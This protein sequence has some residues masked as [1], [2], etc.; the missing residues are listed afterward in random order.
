MASSDHRLRNCLGLSLAALVVSSCGGGHAGASGLFDDQN[1][2]AIGC[3]NHQEQQPGELYTGGDHADTGHILEMMQYLTRHGDEPY[4]D[5]KTATA[6]DAAWGKLY[7]SL[8]G[9]QSN[10]RTV[11]SRP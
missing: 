11:L 6:I 5:G 8:G 7:V 9:Q 1:Q 4:C 2:T 10:V 3:M